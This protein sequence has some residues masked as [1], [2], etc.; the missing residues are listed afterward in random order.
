MQHSPLATA[1]LSELAHTVLGV[2]VRQLFL[3]PA[4]LYT[5]FLDTVVSVHLFVVSD[6]SDYYPLSEKALDW[7]RLRG[8]IQR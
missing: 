5:P 1:F 2:S 7:K 8:E 3:P 6:H 4:A